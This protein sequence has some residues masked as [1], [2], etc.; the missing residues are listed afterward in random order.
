MNR[1]LFVTIDTEED[2]WNSV[3]ILNPSVKNIDSLL[4]F[5]KKCDRYGIIPTYLINYPVTVSSSSRKI[6]EF[7]LSQGKCEIGSHCHPWNTPPFKEEQ[8]KFNSYMCNLPEE[9]VEE[10]IAT[11]HEAINANFGVRPVVFRAGRWGFGKHVL[12]AL[13]RFGYTVDT[14]I[15][16]FT[17]W[18]SSN[19]PDFKC[20]FNQ[21]FYIDS[22][23]FAKHMERGKGKILEVPPTMGY[24]QRNELLCDKF[25]SVATSH[26][27]KRLKLNGML[28]FLGIVNYRWL[29]PETANTKD[30]I[31][32]AERQFQNKAKFINMFF[33]SSSLMHG[34]TPF[35]QD[36]H[37]L[38]IFNN[39]LEDFFKYIVTNKI[40]SLPLSEA[41]RLC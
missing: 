16:P 5:Q 18:L 20:K 34:L 41:S 21:A 3:G 29:S 13:E 1:Y 27:L 39:R 19:G 25:R 26:S 38:G 10:K 23:N 17:S 14:S 24:L 33:H 35:V 11:L 28:E 22:N 9:L 37:E 12:A 4:F 30:M 31:L 6:I 15:T 7:L 36:K 2:T 32:L 40:I 8:S